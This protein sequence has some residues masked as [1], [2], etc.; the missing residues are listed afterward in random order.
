M[1]PGATVRR[2]LDVDGG[3]FPL[4]NGAADVCL[5]MRSRSYPPHSNPPFVHRLQTGLVLSTFYPLLMS[6]RRQDH[7]G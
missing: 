7:S 4:A 5:Q 1:L 3:L 6:M 2:L